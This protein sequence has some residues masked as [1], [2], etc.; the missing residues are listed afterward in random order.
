MI[1]LH[2][3]LVRLHI[4]DTTAAA[5]RKP[6]GNKIT[7]FDVLLAAASLFLVAFAFV[8]GSI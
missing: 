2:P 7:V 6:R 5:S 3:K 1:A 4:L 8:G